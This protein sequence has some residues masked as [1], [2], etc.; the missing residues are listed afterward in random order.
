MLHKRIKRPVFRFSVPREMGTVLSESE[1]PCKTAEIERWIAAARRGDRQALGRLLETC[2]HYLMLIANQELA[3]AIQAK[4]APSDIVQET[5]LEAGRDFPR[6]QGTNEEALLGWLRQILRNNV[7]N[8]HRHFETDKRD[9]EREVVLDDDRLQDAVKQ[10]ETPS[11]QARAREQ[12][13]QLE[14]AMQRLSEHYRQV[15]RMHTSE[16]LTFVQIA[17][18]LDSTADAVRKVWGR[19][20]EELAKHLE[21]PHELP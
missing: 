13:E 2:R 20:V 18:K 19:A 5:F 9:M 10:T 8:L 4:V 21:T 12:D 3:P 11:V 17:E 14:R 1:R 6:F 15:L 7:A 16:G